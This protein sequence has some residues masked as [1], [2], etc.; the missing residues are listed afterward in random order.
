MKEDGK[1]FT[2][3]RE[4]IDETYSIYA[5]PTDTPYPPEDL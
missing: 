1:P 4:Y 2:E 3:I 5:D